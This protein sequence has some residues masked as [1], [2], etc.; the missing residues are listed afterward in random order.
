VTVS[1]KD[2]F[3]DHWLNI[4]VARLVGPASK[5]ATRWSYEPAVLADLRFGKHRGERLA[6]RQ[7]T[8]LL[9]MR[10]RADELLVADGGADAP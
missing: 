7:G 8:S 2:M 3:P 9:R 1:G 5:L 10:H 6:H 4:S